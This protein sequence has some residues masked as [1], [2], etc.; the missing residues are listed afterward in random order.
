[1]VAVDAPLL[2]SDRRLPVSREYGE[3]LLGVLIT[4]HPD[5]YNTVTEL[6]AGEEVPVLAHSDVDREIRAKDDA[7][8][9]G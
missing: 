8:R 7:K 6:L 2:L 9:A 3:P 4:P 5:H 1:M